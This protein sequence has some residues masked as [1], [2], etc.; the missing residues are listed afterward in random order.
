MRP[1]YVKLHHKTAGRLSRLGKEAET[2]GAYRV[3]KRI[4]AVLLNGSGRSSGEISEILKAPLSRVSEWLRNYEEHGYEGLLEGYRPGCP[5]RLSS[6]QKVALG[7]IIDS[8]PIAYGFSSG[9]WTSPMIARVIEEEFDVIYHPVTFA[10]F[11]TTSVSRS[12]VPNAVLRWRTRRSKTVGTGAP[13]P[14]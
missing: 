8:G 13:T 12:N 9:V 11:S 5:S 3:A 10:I 4:H 6:G 2:E 14:T 1:R 7:D